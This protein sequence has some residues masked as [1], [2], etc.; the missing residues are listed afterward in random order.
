MLYTESKNIAHS[1]SYRIFNSGKKCNN[2]TRT[3][4]NCD[5]PKMTISGISKFISAYIF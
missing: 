4:F 3:N 5:L 2:I 1:Q